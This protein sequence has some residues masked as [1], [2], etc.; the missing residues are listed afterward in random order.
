MQN[1]QQQKKSMSI[2]YF[3][4]LQPVYSCIRTQYFCLSMKHVIW[5]EYIL[6]FDVC[7]LAA[8]TYLSRDSVTPEVASSIPVRD[9]DYITQVSNDTVS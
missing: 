3:I 9:R 1:I 5:S 6:L 2:S 8:S 7:S 4:P